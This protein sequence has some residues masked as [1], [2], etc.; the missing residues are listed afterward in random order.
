MYF[1]YKATYQQANS[2]PLF[3]NKAPSVQIGSKCAFLPHAEDDDQMWTKAAVQ[4]SLETCKQI[5]EEVF[6]ANQK[7][8]CL[9]SCW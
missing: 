3:S 9:E 7:F 6:I 5:S 8:K 1:P 2:F 4:S